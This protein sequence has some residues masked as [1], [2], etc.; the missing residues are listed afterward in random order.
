MFEGAIKNEFDIGVLVSGDGDFEPLIRKV[1]KYHK[2]VELWY[3]KKRT[4][5]KLIKASD[6]KKIITKSQIRK[7]YLNFEKK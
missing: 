1:H 5:H 2:K 3:F 6:S 4:S 7:F